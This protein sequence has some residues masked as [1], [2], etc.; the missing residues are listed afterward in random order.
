MK[1]S[2]FV[3]FLLTVQISYAQEPTFDNSSIINLQYSGGEDYTGDITFLYSPKTI[4]ISGNKP[5]T[6]KYDEVTSESK[7]LDGT[8]I[9]FVKRF[10]TGTY[11]NKPFELQHS[12]TFGK[13]G[14]KTIEMC[15]VNIYIDGEKYGEYSGYQN[16]NINI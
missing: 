10:Y 12:I 15:V 14:D 9:G 3:L 11:K 8:L 16:V 2:L 1:N 13:R 6:L 5:I 7:P 4:I